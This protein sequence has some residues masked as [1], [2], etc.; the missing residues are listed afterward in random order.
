MNNLI[1]GKYIYGNSMVHRLDPRSKLIS[2]LIFIG[3]IFWANNVITNVLLIGFTLV[4]I[5]LTGISISYFFSS[6]KPMLTIILVTT[7]FQIFF[8]QTGQ[9]LFSWGIIHITEGG[10]IQSIIIFIRFMLIILLS[11]V[12][13]LT[14][15]PLSLA[16]A[17][18]SLLKPLEKIKVPAHEIGLMLSLSL[19]FVPT[20]ME[21][22]EI[23]MKAQT[24]RGV[25]FNQGNL[26]QRI[27]TLIPILVPL[28]ISSFKRADALALAMEARGYKGSQGR[29]KYRLLTWKYL[30]SLVLL[31]LFIL[32]VLLFYLKN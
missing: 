32:A 4:S 14:T 16:D 1:L 18:E 31:V 24:S 17:V 27:K 28:F 5:M 2:L 7:F 8:N 26:F 15:T 6:L 30:D 20:L 9:M 23:I 22:A 29:S 3:I 10:L 13:T 11:T 25:D 21:D 19:R 12:L